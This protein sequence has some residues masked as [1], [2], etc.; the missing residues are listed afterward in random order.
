MNDTRPLPNGHSDLSRGPMQPSI[1]PSLSDTQA[2]QAAPTDKRNSPSQQAR[3]LRLRNAGFRGAA[4]P[5]RRISPIFGSSSLAPDSF[6]RP[7]NENSPGNLDKRL[8]C[9]EDQP[10]SQVNV[11]QE[12]HKS[13]KKKRKSPRAGFGAIFEDHTATQPY[14]EDTE[15]SW[16][17]ESSTTTSPA[18]ED[19][20]TMRLCEISFNGKPPPPLSSPLAKQVKS[21]NL[22][23]SNLRSASSEAANYIEHLESQ[24]AAVNTKLDSMMSPTVHKARVAK[25]RAL[26]AETHSLKQE[27]AYWEDKFEDRVK[28]ERDHF[29]EAEM[30]FTVRLHQLEDEIGKKDKSLLDLE[31]ETETLRARIKE[32][33][34]LETINATLE[35]RI[36]VLTGL[37]VQSPTRLEICSTASSPIKM[38]LH[39]RTPRPSS[40]LPRVPSSPG[41]A[42]LSRGI[43]SEND[44]WHSRKS[45][46]SNSAISE[47]VENPNEPPPDERRPRSPI[48]M[49]NPKILKSTD[50]ST[51]GSSLNCSAP[52]SSS[53]PTSLQSSTS[54]GTFSWGL[55][56]PP[57]PEA[58]VKAANR[59]RKMR[60]FPSGSCSLKPLILPTASGTPSLPASAPAFASFET[61]MRDFSDVSFDPTTAFLSHHDLSS[62]ILTPTQPARRRSESCARTKA[63]QT[64]EGRRHSTGYS[65][66]SGKPLACK[67][68]SEEP[69]ETVFEDIQNEQ[70]LIRQ[71]SQSLDK[72]LQLAEILSADTFDEGLILANAKDE[73]GEAFLIEKNH[74]GINSAHQREHC[75]ERSEPVTAPKPRRPLCEK[76]IPPLT[77]RVTPVAIT[78]THA[79]GIFTRLTDLI[80]KTK[81]DPVFLAKRILYNAWSLGIARLG[82]MAWWLL[83]LV[84]GSGSSQ[85]KV[86]ADMEITVENVCQSDDST[87]PHFSPETKRTKKKALEPSVMDLGEGADGAHAAWV[88][89]GN[90]R[91]G[92]VPKIPPDGRIISP[93]Q[94][95]KEPH[96]FPC[97]DCTEPSSRRT[98]RL[99]IRFTLAIVLAVGIAVKH[100]PGYLMEDANSHCHPERDKG[101]EINCKLRSSASSTESP[102][103]G[104]QNYIM[105]CNSNGKHPKYHASIQ[106]A[107]ILG[108]A[109]FEIRGAGQNTD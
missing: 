29:A 22:N 76:Y 4:L 84:Y 32:V 3:R 25:L 97:P 43:A 68:P 31:L 36:D 50:S 96:L 78:T 1:S 11:L 99:W 54:F 20:T 81:Q 10:I 73:K 103:I 18:L 62:P 47:D 90:Q 104:S 66:Q 101:L 87:W 70:R 83:G 24:L 79:Y 93:L 91:C 49:E 15:H 30:L 27:L 44:F 63:L 19:A 72:E 21:R 108:P 23:K 65:S 102:S 82:G 109:D 64:L 55:P 100:G 42:R 92:S 51:E 45:F 71:R 89:P 38:D 77:K 57:D 37:V 5:P 53:R 2:T 86:A 94:S 107:E 48:L 59:Q 69:L 105:Q 74:A 52:S 33:E 106:F 85:K 12:L 40:M 28:Q 35:K 6:S 56:L 17:N 16:Y 39:K 58:N 60:R 13:V 80:S 88:G 67:T 34:G 98:F 75:P 61:P 9:R 7:V 95:R 26:T 46:D 8:L 14:G 41:G